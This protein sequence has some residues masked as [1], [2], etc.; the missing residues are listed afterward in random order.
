V[1]QA[2]ACKALY[3]GSIPVAASLFRST[4]LNSTLEIIPRTSRGAYLILR[5]LA[6]GVL[7]ALAMTWFMKSASSRPR[8]S[9]AC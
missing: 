3:T 2:R 1:A 8:S 4:F 6:F 9:V 7:L 5:T